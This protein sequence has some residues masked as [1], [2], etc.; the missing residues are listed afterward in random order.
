VR[1]RVS[2]HDVSLSG[3]RAAPRALD[4]MHHLGMAALRQIHG[5]RT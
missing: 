1:E 3:G 5:V 4:H 2:R